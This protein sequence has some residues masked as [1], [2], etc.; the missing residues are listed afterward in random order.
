MLNARIRKT[1]VQ[2]KLPIYSIGDPGDL[3]YDYQIIGKKQMTFAKIL[4]KKNDFSKKLYHQKN[5]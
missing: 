3:T 2:K 4:N 5:Q 1:F